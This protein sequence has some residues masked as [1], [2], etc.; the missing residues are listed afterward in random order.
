MD[1][2]DLPMVLEAWTREKVEISNPRGVRCHPLARHGSLHG[3]AHGLPIQTGE[4]TGSSGD[5][6]RCG[7]QCDIDDARC[8]RDNFY[9]RIALKHP[10]AIASL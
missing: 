2:L 5:S 9:H 4:E 8:A 1:R 6:G 10:E 3:G 7:P